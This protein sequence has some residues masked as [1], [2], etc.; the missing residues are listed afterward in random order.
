MIR[1]RVQDFDHWKSVFLELDPLR[2]EL[3][4][5]ALQLFRIK[6]DPQ[7]VLILQEWSDLAGADQFYHSEDFRSAAKR[8]QNLAP[9]S[10]TLLDES[11]VAPTA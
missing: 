2:Q 5:T 11:S 10:I 9:P 1:L 4:Q 8:A 7:G 3:G 6:D